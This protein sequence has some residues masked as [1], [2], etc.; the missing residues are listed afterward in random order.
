MSRPLSVPKIVQSGLC[1]GCGLCQSI[2]G[3]D[4]LA[5]VTTSEGRERP[6][7][8]SA[9]SEDDLKLI[10]AVCPGLHAPGPSREQAEEFDEIWGPK[11][12][13][14]LIGWAG[15]PDVR[16]RAAT[17]GVL[18]ALGQYLLASG[19]VERVLHVR[20]QD[21]APM[22]T[23]EQVSKTPRDMLKGM[24]SRYGPGAPLTQVHRLLEEGHPFA[25]IAKPCDLSAIENLARRDPRVN[26]LIPYRLCMVCGGASEMMKSWDLLKDWGI[27]EDELSLFRYRG[28]G[29]PG[30][31]RAETKD[32]RAFE[33]TYQALW[34]DEGTWRLQFRC[35]ICPDAIGEV[36]DIAASDVWPGG[37]PEGEDEGFNGILTRTAKGAALLQEAV[38][39]GYIVTDE[40]IGFRDMDDFQPHQVRKKRAVWARL[41][42][43][44]AAGHPVLEG[45]EL[46]IADLARDM[47]ISDNLRQARGT[48]QRLKDGKIAE[49]EA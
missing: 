26:A 32:G 41:A 8:V 13:P 7:E 17:G 47:T 25:V 24:G 21:D 5:L 19:K 10:N 38:A 18:T 39:A 14:W 22:R 16:Y 45:E 11:E 33:T 49:P 40:E 48:R 2:A 4:K 30:K 37:G 6:H 27:S 9:P 44:K 46:R 1:I 31:T 3:A 34:E 36:A 43:L 42:G 35:K 20:P 12:G 28:Y 23:V 29:N 15:D